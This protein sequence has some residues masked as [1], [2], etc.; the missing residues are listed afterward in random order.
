VRSV[1]ELIDRIL[2]CSQ[3]P[4]GKRQ[5]E[6]QREL[7]AHVEDFVIAAR[8]GGRG[9]DE[10]EKL[11]LAH[12]GDPS[13]IARG[14]A[15]VYRYE[16][17]RLRI[18]VYTL[19]TVLLASTLFPAILATQAGLALGFGTRVFNPFTT[20]HTVIEALDI[21]MSVAAYLGL[22]SLE[23]LFERRP[24]QKAAFLLVA[25]VGVVTVLCRTAG[26]HITVLV[27]GLVNGVFFRAVQ[28]FVTPRVAR[29]GI[30]AIC[31][32]V[33]GFVS[34]LMWSPVSNMH[35]VASCASWLAMG[36]GYL[37]MIDLAARVDAALV[38]GLQ[39]IQ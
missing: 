6:I 32:L 31:F 17:R 18:F 23:G 34:A 9:Q 21:V 22:V 39:R 27:F 30:V 14:F 20:R 33:A 10:I 3:I 2:S 12:F 24:F 7:R 37:V 5:R 36:A 16:R 13:Q 25:I 26:L 8:E 15:W 29:A 28:Q 35:R 11:V 4:P 19:S 38:N 1:D